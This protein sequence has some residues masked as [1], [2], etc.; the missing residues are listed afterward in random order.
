MLNIRK[1]KIFDKYRFHCNYCGNDSFKPLWLVKLQLIFSDEIFI[2]CSRCH[3]TS[4]F[5]QY[6]N[7]R[8]DSTNKK[9]KIQNKQENWDRRLVK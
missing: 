5:K 9:E 3:K 6:F 7:L 1:R 4:C 2:T 8:H